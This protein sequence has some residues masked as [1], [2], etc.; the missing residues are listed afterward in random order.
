MPSVTTSML[1]F[2]YVLE[3]LKDKNKYVGFTTDLRRRL[4]EHGD[5]ESFSTKSRLPFKLIYYG[6]CS[7]KEDA[8]RREIYL[9]TTRGRRFLAK[10]LK[11]YHQSKL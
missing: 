8:C 1:Y 6:A 3:S 11:T 2:V 9:K 10:R 4:Q 7:D 5:G